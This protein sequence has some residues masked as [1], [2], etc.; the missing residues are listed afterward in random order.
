M[1]KF[2]KNL[3]PL[4]KILLSTMVFFVYNWLVV[5][6]FLI[7]YA[8]AN[9]S[10]NEW[11]FYLAPL[12]YF[13]LFLPSLIIYLMVI[14]KNIKEVKKMRFIIWPTCYITLF[15]AFH[16]FLIGISPIL[17]WFMILTLPIGFVWF[18][19]IEIWAIVLDI[20][21]K[22]QLDKKE[23]KETTNN[24]NDKLVYIIFGCLAGLLVLWIAVP[25]VLDFI[26]GIGLHKPNCEDGKRIIKMAINNV[27]IDLSKASFEKISKLFV[28]ELW[29]KDIYEPLFGGE[30]NV[31]S[32]PSNYGTS[33][34]IRY[35]NGDYIYFWFYR[36][37]E[38]SKE[39]ENCHWSMLGSGPCKR[40]IFI[41]ENWK[42]IE[43]DE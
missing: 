42:I 20:K 39:A 37:W 36:E 13:L 24:K 21:A 1:V 15:I 33:F 9:E 40:W 29:R 26:S 38:C 32:S 10:T 27:D 3:S 16:M 8:P 41:D 34:K 35:Y 2:Y 30:Y 17:L 19:V 12:V 4:A 23:L 22:K 7:L 6:P 5:Y 18:V 14:I 11:W 43:P 25:S 28:E 31:I